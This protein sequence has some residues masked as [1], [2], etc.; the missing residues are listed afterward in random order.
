MN[1]QFYRAIT[2]V[3]ANSYMEAV[4][5]WGRKGAG[6]CPLLSFRAPSTEAQNFNTNLQLVC[7]VY[8]YVEAFTYICQ[9]Y[10]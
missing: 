9:L 5:R 10:C 8:Q 1:G 3:A 4:K 2:R 6:N 7:E